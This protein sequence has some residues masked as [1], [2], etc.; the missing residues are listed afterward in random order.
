MGWKGRSRF[1]A[2]WQPAFTPRLYVPPSRAS[3]RALPFM[4]Y[5]PSGPQDSLSSSPEIKTIRI[6][7][8][9]LVPRTAYHVLNWEPDQTTQAHTDERKTSGVPVR[10]EN[11]VMR[12]GAWQ[13][14]LPPR[15]GISAHL[16]LSL[17]FTFAPLL[18]V[19]TRAGFAFSRRPSRARVLALEGP[20]GSSSASR[21]RF[22]NSP[23]V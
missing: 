9:S 20:A 23:H 7:L 17:A 18:T 12:P 1:Q 4:R 2:F 22:A 3:F 15:S 5:H 21:W 6:I 16:L 19:R 8:R 10:N 11:L 14:A 13:G